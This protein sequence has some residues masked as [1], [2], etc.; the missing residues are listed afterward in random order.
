[1]SRIVSFDFDPKTVTPITAEEVAPAVHAGRYCW[2]DVDNF[3]DAAAILLALEIEP[4]TLEWIE[5]DRE[6]AQLHI[7]KSCIHC[8]LVETTPVGRS[9]KLMILHV[10]IGQNFLLTLRTGHS[11]LVE[12]MQE[13]YE[14]DF[15]ENAQSGGFLLFELADHLI[16]G[17]RE[18]L[19]HLSAGVDEIQAKLL[20]DIGDEILTEVSVLTRALLDYRNAVVSARETI[21]ELSTRRS[22]FINPS[23]QPFLERQTKPLE[24]LTGDAATERTVLSESLNLYMGL[25]SHRTNKVVNRL[26]IVS[27]IFLPLNFF[28]AIYGMNFDVMPELEWRYGYLAFWGAAATLVCVMLLMFRRRRWI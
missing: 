17:Y 24:R 4:A 7:G 11:L 23:T 13:T 20:G 16:H 25:V 6:L 10:I 9:L 18:T 19:T 1:M 2:A 26:T 8:T 5:E 22:A 12:R 14:K 21:Y 28:A 15:V 27:M 3:H